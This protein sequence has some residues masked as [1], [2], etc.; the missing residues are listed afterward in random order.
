[1]SWT[2]EVL[3]RAEMFKLAM[4]CIFWFWPYSASFLNIMGLTQW[5][6]GGL[7]RV[8]SAPLWPWQISNINNGWMNCGF[9]AIDMF[10]SD[11]T[12]TCCNLTDTKDTKLK[13][14]INLLILLKFCTEF[15]TYYVDK[16]NKCSLSCYWGKKV[17]VQS[18]LSWRHSY[19]WK[20][21]RSLLL[22]ME[23]P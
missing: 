4:E 2:M 14:L 23:N 18:H 22:Y 11:M 5:K 17:Q 15:S 16:T 19:G 7:A 9:L 20:W 6:I 12:F 10:P 13:F 8:Y 21:D 3:L 1:M